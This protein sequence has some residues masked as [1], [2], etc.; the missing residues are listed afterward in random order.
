MLVPNVKS[1][2]LRS[3]ARTAG[4][5]EAVKLGF[6]FALNSELR[7]QWI[8]T[9]PVGFDCSCFHTLVSC[10]T[11]RIFRDVLRS[12]VPEL[13]GPR[14]CN[15]HGMHDGD[16]S[17]E[18]IL[19]IGPHPDL[20]EIQ[21]WMLALNYGTCGGNPQSND[22]RSQLYCVPGRLGFDTDPDKRKL[23]DQQII[24]LKREVIHEDHG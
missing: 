1:M 14:E 13:P 18:L 10:L 24:I 15:L 22:R 3:V 5:F 17:A 23:Q 6:H 9:H 2:T 12:R 20:S 16:L 4:P 21:V 8:S 11:N 19:E 7:W